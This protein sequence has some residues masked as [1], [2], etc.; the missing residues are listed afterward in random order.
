MNEIPSST[1]EAVEL[2]LARRQRGEAVDA[3]TFAALHP[4][5]AP[6]LEGALESLIALECAK[7]GLGAGQLPERIGLFRVIRELGRGGMGRFTAASRS[8]CC[9]RSSCRARLR[10]RA[11]AARPSSRRASIIPVSRRSTAPEWNTI[12]LG[13]RCASWKAA[14]S[15]A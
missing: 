13:S 4:Q 3:K 1:E 5:L 10:A 11:S 2:F 7:L 6:E 12:A 15:R 9:R 8:R 14:R